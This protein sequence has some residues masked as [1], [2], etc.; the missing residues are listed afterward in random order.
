MG[1]MGGF[2][3][4]EVDNSTTN[5]LLSAEID[6]ETIGDKYSRMKSENEHLRVKKNTNVTKI[7]SFQGYLKQRNVFVENFER[8][9]VALKEILQI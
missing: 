5:A 3:G 1:K 9:N 4:D 8:E 7:R 6:N 2:R